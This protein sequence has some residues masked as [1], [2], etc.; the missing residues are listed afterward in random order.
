MSGTEE[1]RKHIDDVL[2]KQAEGDA[3][4]YELLQVS[5]GRVVYKKYSGLVRSFTVGQ[6][7]NSFLL[8]LLNDMDSVTHVRDWLKVSLM[9]N[10]RWLSNVNEDGWPKKLL[11]SPDLRGLVKEADKAMLRANGKHS[12]KSLDDGHEVVE[13][14]CQDGWTI[15]RML[16]PEA[17]DLES[18]LMQ[19]CVGDGA[20]DRILSAGG[21]EHFEGLFSLRDRAGKPHATIEVRNGLLS[22]VQGK[23]NMAPIPKY[24][25]HIVG[26]IRAR[27]IAFEGQAYGL[28]CDR[29]GDIHAIDDLPEILEVVGALWLKNSE[30]R[31]IRIPRVI[32]C[33]QL[34]LSGTR[35]ADVPE[36]IETSQ[37]V[38]IHDDCLERLPSSF[39]GRGG[40]A[41]FQSTL[42]R[43]PDDMKVGGALSLSHMPNLVELPAAL[44]VGGAL[45]LSNLPRLVELPDHLSVPGSLTLSKTPALR[46]LPLGLTVHGALE[47]MDAEIEFS[48]IPDDTRFRALDISN[49]PITR[50]DTRCFLPSVG[51]EDR[52]RVLVANQSGLVEIAGEPKFSI[53]KLSDCAF[54]RL[55]EGTTVS[56]MLDISGTHIM[57][58]PV[59]AVPTITLLANQCDIRGIPAYLDCE[60]VELCGSTVA[61]P[62]T[63]SVVG[64][65]DMSKVTATSQARSMKA[66]SIDMTGVSGSELPHEV[67]TKRL[68]ITD[69]P[70]TR[71][72]R[73]V[74]AGSIQATAGP[75][76]IEEGVVVGNGIYVQT[77]KDMK[78][79][80]KTF[81]VE[82]ARD[83]FAR[84]GTLFTDMG[85][86]EG[87]MLCFDEFHR[88]GEYASLVERRRERTTGPRPSHFRNVFGGL[89]NRLS[90]AIE[91]RP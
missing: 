23:Q 32:K 36:L 86:K 25:P 4:L 31:P 77:R 59:S 43:L 21:G 46:G 84:T 1:L 49:T 38:A 51:A 63:F 28:V 65:L 67:E 30:D 53:L 24:I 41:I 60:R 16:T 5:V 70:I 61:F 82:S 76:E 26:F 79:Y 17:L 58:I 22:Q 33:H 6:V 12:R 55:P 57:D 48:T 9:D 20:Y 13:Y 37:S 3:K 40:I 14:E 10:A 29:N 90:R 80:L 88:F 71:I 7:R 64:D 85:D 73:G 91:K 89:K 18:A 68:N 62:A 74:R 2:E 11:K 78:T 45:A 50:V 47:L 15:V 35:F 87:F 69:T 56:H 19:H 75:L 66:L 27:K 44:S 42:E 34:S 52:N 72:H 83:E 8:I 54:D 81:T 39:G